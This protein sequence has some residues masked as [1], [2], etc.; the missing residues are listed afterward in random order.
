MKFVSG[1]FAAFAAE[2][3]AIVGELKQH[4]SIAS[5]SA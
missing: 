5:R 2:Q 1:F 4:I 3:R